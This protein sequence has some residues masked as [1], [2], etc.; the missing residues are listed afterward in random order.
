MRRR[1]ASELR[2]GQKMLSNVPQKGKE[3]KVGERT[4]SLKK[5][6]DHRR[7]RVV[8]CGKRLGRGGSICLRKEGGRK[9]RVKRKSKGKGRHA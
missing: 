6:R 3:K 8:C 5:G 7:Q 2:Q 1:M 4:V 9:R